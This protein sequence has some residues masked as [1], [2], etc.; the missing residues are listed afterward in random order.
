MK[1][2]RLSKEWIVFLAGQG[3]DSRTTN[4]TSLIFIVLRNAG[5]TPTVER[6]KL[7]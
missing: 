3:A 7:K 5:E 4:L 2:E 6:I 1:Y